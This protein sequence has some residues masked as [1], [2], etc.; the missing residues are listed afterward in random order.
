MRL[1]GYALLSIGF[2]WL[3]DCQF[4]AGPRAR[5]IVL[6]HYDQL[7][8]QQSFTREQVEQSIRAPV[9]QLVDALPWLIWPGLTMLAGGILLDRARRRQKSDGHVV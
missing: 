6:H 5:T 7:P 8:N 4:C 9:F 3:L 1:L 2:L